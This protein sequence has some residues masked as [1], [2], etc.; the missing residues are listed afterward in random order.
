MWLSHLS[1]PKSSMMPDEPEGPFEDTDAA[2][3]FDE[4]DLSDDGEDE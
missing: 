3:L 2:L 4:P 1:I